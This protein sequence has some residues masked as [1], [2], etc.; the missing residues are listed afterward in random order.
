MHAPN[1]NI[2][3]A[4]SVGGKSVLLANPRGF[5]AG[6]RRAIRAVED[7]LEAYG[8][9][10][11]VRRAIVHNRRVVESLEQRGAV[12]VQ[13]VSEIPEGA[14]TILSAHGS[15]AIVKSE[16]QQANLRVVDAICPLVAK[17]HSEVVQWHLQG[18][19]VIL[20]GH[21]DHPEI[22]GTIGQIPRREIFV[23][24]N[25]A[26]VD[27]LQLA[28]LT[29][30]AYAVQTTFSVGEAATVIE[31]IKARFSD[32][33]GPRSSDI[34]Y[35]TTNR[36][37]AV[38]AI[39]AQCD[40]MLIVGDT[41]SSNARR[42]V[43]TAVAAGCPQAIL[44]EGAD[45]LPRCFPAGASVVGL[46]AAASAPDEVIE[47]VCGWLREQGFAF[48][49]MAGA[50]EAMKFR[51]VSVA[52]DD[53]KPSTSLLFAADIHKDVDEAILEAIGHSPSRSMRLADAMRYAATGGGK[54]FRAALTVTVTH[55][56]GGSRQMALR[57]AAA[58]ECVHAQS[59]VHD[60][61]PCMDNDD[62]RRG[63]PTLHR[64][65]DEATAVLAG[66]AL[67]ALAFEI[68]ADPRTHPEAEVR[69]QLVLRL[70]QT[71][72]QDGLAGG[73]MM[74]LYPSENIT[75]EELIACLSGKTGALVRFAVE[76]GILLGR[77]DARRRAQLRSFAENLGLLFQLQDDFLDA[78]GDERAVGKALRKDAANKR[79]NAIL[80][81]GSEAAAREAE[82][83]LASCKTL[84]ESFGD[85]AAGL[86]ELTRFAAQRTC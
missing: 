21:V 75:R 65:F 4:L 47:E 11:Y 77:T 40:V 32:C 73:Q 23:V 78:A 55:M 63:R 6:V 43:E 69:T 18:R 45:D 13:E 3:D 67:L 59:L 84:L 25:V 52:L 37:T 1:P 86:L 70:A 9:P 19:R 57:A 83:L 53:R 12:F 81:L 17:V 62:L 14:V 22:I 51:P 68:L 71:M 26:D 16:A 28:A 74:D 80:V 20:I 54:R 76:A 48:N 38:A 50:E 44:V 56:L 7:A 64:R 66:D 46:S 72:G 85:S 79:K 41:T 10:V 34:C 39:A 2:D 82:R 27:A 42:L 49:E 60:D 31:A 36:Q 5:C 61:L 58:I 24:G 35:A 15:A 8:A 29:P 33:V 30:V